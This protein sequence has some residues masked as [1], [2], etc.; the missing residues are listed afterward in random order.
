[1]VHHLAVDG[2]S[3]RPLLEDLETA[4]QQL[5]AGQTV[6][7]PPKTTSF[8]AWAE[9]LQ[10]YAG[11]E[12][13]RNELAYWKS[14]TEPQRVA[15]AVEHPSSNDA[16]AKNTEGSC[17]TL[18]FALSAAET[19]AL[20]QQ[21]P[22][23]Y[24]T[25]INDVL[26]TALARAWSQWSGSP[27]LFTN[28]EGHGRENLF[29]DVDLSRTVGWFTSIFPLRLELPAPGNRWEPGAA[30]KAIKEQLRQVPQHGIGYGILR[31][32]CPDVDLAA[33]PE[34]STVFNY[35]GQFD[36]VLAG[37]KLFRFASESTGPWHSPQQRRRHAL[38]VNSLVIDGRLELSWTYSENQHADASIRK[39]ADEFL[40]ALKELIAHCL[41]SKAGGRTTSDFP[42]ARLNQATLDRLVAGRRDIEDIY[43]LSPIQTLFYSANPGAELAVFDQWHCTLAGD[44]NISAFQRAWQE[45]LQRHAILRSTIHG[46]GLP[47]PMQ[48]VHRDVQL[49]WTIEDWLSTS[50]KDQAARWSTFLREDRATPLNLTEAP[51]MRFA[52]LRLAED[53][54]K[55]IWSVPALLLDGWSWPLVFRDVSRLYEAFSQQ[56]VAQLEPVRPYRDY[57]EW[58]SQQSSDEAGEFWRK[59]LAGF[60]EPTRLSS[61]PPEP[62]AD[63]RYAEHSVPL[64]AETTNAL[65]VA[66]RG[67]HLTHEHTGAGRV[68]DAAEPPERFRGRGVRRGVRR[69]ADGS[70][71]G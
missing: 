40:K 53:K 42:L 60:L 32:L 27:V 36:H 45:T 28:L 5:K 65:Q 66:A 10:K 15:K 71:R 35:L 57:L 51:A 39:L 1:M 63:E 52:L 20:L 46:D 47:E 8:K 54:W 4:Y 62:V 41:S 29:D 18:K 37:S 26:L 19:Q 55:F 69:T 58:L 2:V 16:R 68:G 34:P 23:A 64:S 25:Q 24:N 61:E 67:L 21:V 56:R 7:L 44:L 14:V 70:A 17:R 38:E 9:Q 33:L 13:L 48:V 11:A 3:W 31:Y 22:A 49:P 12:S 43:P 59:N 6:Q 30:L 50:S